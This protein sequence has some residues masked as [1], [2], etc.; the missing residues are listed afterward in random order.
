ME[1]FTYSVDVFISG[2]E[3]HI[4]NAC[5]TNS[6]LEAYRCFTE[7]LDLV[8][9]DIADDV[10]IFEYDDSGLANIVATLSSFDC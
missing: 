3:G 4:L 9:C 1:N 7:Y 6:I 2:E 8:E 5:K 10:V